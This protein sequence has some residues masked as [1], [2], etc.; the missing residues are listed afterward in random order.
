MTIL[1]F[2]EDKTSAD[3][4]KLLA[5]KM[6]GNTAKEKTQEFGTPLS[7]GSLSDITL[8]AHTSDEA[9]HI[10]DRTPL[11]LATDFEKMFHG[12]DKTELR[13]IY[14]ISCE[15]GM[16]KGANLPL[17]QKFVDA[18]HSKGFINLK[19]H[20]ISNPLGSDIETMRV[21]VTNQG[22]VTMVPQGAVN[23]IVFHD[24]ASIK[25]DEDIIELRKIILDPTLHHKHA[26]HVRLVADLKRLEAQQA[27]GD[28]SFE[29]FSS[30]D[31]KKDMDQPYNTFTHSGPVARISNSAAFAIHYL[32]LEKLK[33]ARQK[34]SGSQTKQLGYLNADI[35][36]LE[37]GYTKNAQEIMAD[38][39]ASHKP[40]HAW[41][42]S[43]YYDSI[44]SPLKLQLQA[45]DEQHSKDTAAGYS[46]QRNASAGSGSDSDADEDAPLLSHK[47]A[48]D[49]H[50]PVRRSP[51]RTYPPRFVTSNGDDVLP[52]TTVTHAH[53]V[54]SNNNQSTLLANLKAYRNLRAN[55]WNYPSG[56]LSILSVVYFILDS[57]TGSNHFSSKQCKAKLD[58]ADKL[59]E[60]I[61]GNSDV[62][63]SS[64]DKCALQD[65]RL[66]KIVKDHCEQ[67]N[68][69]IE[70]LTKPSSN[71]GEHDAKHIR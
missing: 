20:A 52:K 22:G 5:D 30:M 18:M 9:K 21:A 42:T 57:L 49:A 44:I 46:V 67:S 62:E 2:K 34:P 3:S 50:Q 36:S 31:Y 6:N 4:L 58:A 43:S 33:L 27:Q 1:Y 16:Y 64:T 37:K 68:C 24:K 10:G 28:Q 12:K 13:D 23:A 54:S 14:L 29:F 15:A 51:A 35:E 19:V 38:L 41:Q 55:E 48:M 39:T 69:D 8:V 7:L 66:G 45:F 25:L 17:A 26:E 70:S 53:H 61:E 65:G 63:F 60:K 32:Q 59:I 11:Q 47:V 71:E 40:K 56:F